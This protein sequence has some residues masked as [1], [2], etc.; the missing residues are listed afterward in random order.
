MDFIL[1]NTI[2][3]RN[4]IMT[5]HITINEGSTFYHDYAFFKEDNTTPLDLIESVQYIVTDGTDIV[6]DWTDLG[7]L[8]SGRI[9]ISGDI[10]RID[11]VG[12]NMRFILIAVVHN[13]GERITVETQY[14]IQD[15]KTITP[16]LIFPV[17][18]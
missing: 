9:T 4:K 6:V 10:N 15:L 2:L 5:T 7:I 12:R 14:M 8:D 3:K 18:P 11:P 17:I 16:T 1:N 13:G